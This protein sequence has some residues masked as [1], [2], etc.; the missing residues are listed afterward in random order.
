M[1]KQQKFF[2]IM[3]IVDKPQN[4]SPQNQCFIVYSMKFDAMVRILQPFKW[5][6]LKYTNMA[7]TVTFIKYI[8][9]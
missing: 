8:Y 2:Y 1:G 6:Y 4:F 7:E 5:Y 3:N 9:Y